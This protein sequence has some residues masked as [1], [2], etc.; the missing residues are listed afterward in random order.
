MMR[1][2]DNIRITYEREGSQKNATG[3]IRSYKETKAYA[4]RNRA[5]PTPPESKAF[6][7][8]YLEDI[9]DAKRE[10]FN[11]ENPYGA[12]VSEVVPGSGAEKAGIQ[13][14]DY[15]YGIDQYR[16]GADQ[17]LGAILAKY[18]AGDQVAVHLV[19]ARKNKVVEMVFIPKSETGQAASRNKCE[20]AFL[21]VTE[22]PSYR[23][24]GV[25]I[26]IVENSTAQALGL[27][28][29]DII[30]ALNGTPVADWDDIGY[31]LDAIEPGNQI[32]GC[33]PARR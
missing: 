11:I 15:I 13:P 8:V 23:E 25:S 9:N 17:S 7:G 5:K 12:F 3:T 31:V 2:G 32:T 24:M 29:G 14:L 10:Y 1:P 4:S 30:T 27:Q 18:K 28:R 21:G 22:G 6:L 33:L 26:D 20:Q 19:R 16:V